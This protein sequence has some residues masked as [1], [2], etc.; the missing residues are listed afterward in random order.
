M[1]QK[2]MYSVNNGASS[3]TIVKEVNY[4]KDPA[5]FDYVR[6][7]IPCQNACPAYTNIPAYIRCLYESRY[8]RSYELNRIVNIMPGVLGRICSRPCEKM[9]RHGAN[10]LGL[11]V[12]IC[13]IKRAASD[14]KEEGHVYFEQF[15]APVGKR[16]CIIGS[17]PAGLAAAHD[18]TVIGIDVTILESMEE[19]GGML[20]Y[21]IPEFRLPRDI[22]SAEI[23]SVL[24]LGIT[25]KTGVRVGEEIQLSDLMLQYDAV[26]LAAGCYVSKGLD[27]PGE[28]LAGVYPGLQFLM[29][30]CSGNTNPI[31][32]KV[33]VVGA[34]FTAFDCARTALRMGAQDV[35]I[36]IRGTE[37]DLRVTEEEILEAKREGVKIRALTLT[38]Q[39]LGNGGIT[40]VEFLRT[41]PG[42]SPSSGRSPMVP[43]QGSEFTIKADT[44]IVAIG[45]GAEPLDISGEKDYRGVVKGNRESGETS[46]AGLYVAG[47]YMTGPSTVIE[48]IASGRRV[49]EKIAKDVTGKNFREWVVR[50]E[51]A[52]ITDRSRSWDFINR[53]EMPTLSVSE[54][55]NS[56]APE[57]ELGFD[58]EMA[59]DEARRCYLCY[60]HYEIDVSRCIYCRY[61]IDVAP[62]DCIKLVDEVILNEKG[63]IE[64][65][66]ETTD[67][68]SVNAVIIDNS[69]CIRCG[70]CMRVCPVNCITVSKVELIER[71]LNGGRE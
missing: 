71:V 63:A 38:K 13:H 59:L 70:E 2:R 64:G 44:V 11:P 50:V 16:V 12:N 60:L 43:I 66:R 26:L 68:K 30:L 46:V 45:Q 51:D 37:K 18:L 25:L 3:R 47:D 49:A 15:F 5:D 42:E 14:F 10:E 17:G 20:R 1:I 28:H 39:I 56:Q 21:G 24:R 54:R 35:T 53:K 36:C 52:E 7:N 67:W 34:G 29:N 55:I 23:N 27:V 62:R 41:R 8:G 65:L 61:C 31:G 4:S 58:R 57:V 33:L 22:L 48:S 40:G 9:C 19:P 32:N 6:V 69:R